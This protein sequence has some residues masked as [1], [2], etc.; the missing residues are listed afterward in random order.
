MAQRPLTSKITIYTMV[1]LGGAGRQAGV[2][3]GAIVVAQQAG[4]N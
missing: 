3:L 1:I 2:V 4:G